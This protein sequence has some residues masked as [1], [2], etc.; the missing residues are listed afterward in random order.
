MKYV[1]K[2]KKFSFLLILLI[3][4]VIIS[5]SYA[6][7][8]Y[9]TSDFNLPKEVVKY[10]TIRYNY[11]PTSKAFEPQHTDN[12]EFKD[13]KLITFTTDG[14]GSFIR[15]T[16]N[17][18]YEYD[19]KGNLV[20]TVTKSSVSEY[21]DYFSYDSKGRLILISNQTTSNP[22]STSFKYNE[23]GFLLSV[24]KK[25][26]DFTGQEFLYFD[27]IDKNNYKYTEN[28]YKYKS[29]E[30]LYISNCVVKN[31]L[32]ISEKRSDENGN[33][34]RDDT[35]EYN[36]YRHLIS[37]KEK[38]GNILVYNIGYDEKGTEIKSRRGDVGGDFYN[39]FSKVTYKDG[40]TSGNTDFA[41]YFTA[42]LQLPLLKMPYNTTPKDKYKVR[43]TGQST[44]DVQNSKGVI[45]TKPSEGL[46]FEQKDFLFYDA[47]NGENSVLFGL[48]TDAYKANEWYDLLTYNSPSGKYIVVN[49]D[50]QFLVFEKGKSADIT[51]LTLHKGI[52][53]NTLV[54]A[55]NGKE[56]YFVPYLNQ[57]QA[58]VIYPLEIIS[59]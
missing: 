11:N 44:F 13:G 32:K 35:F 52:D 41:P 6:Q 51:G 37:L 59:K 34:L 55:E 22:I 17:K 19:A 31:G 40:T 18:N 4:S 43:K 12:Y 38:T 8:K 20:K 48:F 23:K 3:L 10:E 57:I 39:A 2:S 47:N 29:T 25:N 1:L 50:W 45:L 15:F 56:K 26:G 5:T 14:N 58:L 49:S 27:Y 33:I 42:G 9:L 36:N 28:Y 46:I 54:V 30:K 16:T 53:G 7:E 21:A 24:T